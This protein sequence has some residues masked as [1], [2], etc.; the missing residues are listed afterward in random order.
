MNHNKVYITSRGKEH[1]FIPH[2]FDMSFGI[3][4][5]TGP[6]GAIGSPG[7]LPFPIK[8]KHSWK[9]SWQKRE[10]R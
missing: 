4:G 6:T 5:S 1:T 7:R 8:S 3:T 2:I 10:R 9:N